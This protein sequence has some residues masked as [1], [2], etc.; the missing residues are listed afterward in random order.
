MQKNENFLALLNFFFKAQAGLSKHVLEAT[1]LA[2]AML[3]TFFRSL[4]VGRLKVETFLAVSDQSSFKK[5]D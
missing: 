3:N 4:Y 2:L 1:L 5:G